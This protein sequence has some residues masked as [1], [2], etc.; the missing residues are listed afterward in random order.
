[1]ANLQEN[2]GLQL[3]SYQDEVVSC[4]GD[5]EVNVFE[6]IHKRN[7]QCTPTTSLSQAHND[8]LLCPEYYRCKEQNG[9]E[10]GCV[11]LSSLRLFTGDPTYC[12]QIPDIISAHKLIRASGLPNFLGLRIPVH[13]QLNVKAWRFHLSDYW[14]Q[15]LVDLIEYGFPLDF[16]RSFQ[17]G[18]ILDNHTSALQFSD[19]VDQYI[20][21]ELQHGALL[22]PFDHKPCSLHVS[23]F[24]A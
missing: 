7:G 9:V 15:Q 11:P 6:P 21:E 1:M 12:E 16:D 4:A 19:H 14:D 17:L 20:A 5:T 22:G 13:T 2:D 23:P 24:M 8:Q 3:Q 18:H 10:F